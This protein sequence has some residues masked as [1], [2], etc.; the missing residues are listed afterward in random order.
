[1]FDDSSHEVFSSTAL[2]RVRVNTSSGLRS[3]YEADDRSK[4]GITGS[5]AGPSIEARYLSSSH[6]ESQQSV[7]VDR[8][9]YCHAMA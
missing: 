4:Y 9:N 1:M 5:A 3:T 8:T 6:S 7:N 2:L